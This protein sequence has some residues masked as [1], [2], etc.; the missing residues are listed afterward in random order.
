LCYYP[1]QAGGPANTL[2]WLSLALDKTGFYTKILSTDFGLLPGKT[3]NIFS[4]LIST[5]NHQVIFV[6]STRSEYLKIGFKSINDCDIVQF[7]SIF[8]PPTLPFLIK[9]L[10]REKKVIISPRGELYPAA[11]KIKSFQKKVWLSIIKLFQTKI[12]FHATNEIEMSIISEY[13]PRAKGISL[14]PNF[15]KI[16]TKQE[17]KI[18]KNKLLFLG[19]I[20]PIKNIDL[21]IK[22]ISK[23]KLMLVNPVKLIIAGVARLPYELTYQSELFKLVKELNLE[24]SVTFIGHIEGE[25]KDKLI[26]SSYALILPSRSENFGN[27]VLEALAQGTPV[28]A[29]KNTPWKILV[30]NNAGYW[31][32]PSEEAIFNSIVQIINLKKQDYLQ[33]RNNASSLC[34]SKFDVDANIFI[35]E[36]LYKRITNVQK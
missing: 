34:S 11:L 14:I 28:I 10:F 16:G 7:S 20:N 31:V 32:A 12:Y 19:R 8:F 33:M 29:S 36:N 24:D 22:A 30:E 13:F 17:I 6:N 4:E 5:P 35:W 27:V 1:S 2:Y 9:A 15:V 3:L 21:L 25:E 26:S 23:V 18:V